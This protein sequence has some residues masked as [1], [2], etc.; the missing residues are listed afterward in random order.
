MSYD[1]PS[2]GYSLT[3]PDIVNLQSN[4]EVRFI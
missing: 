2:E 3:V 1:T 4:D